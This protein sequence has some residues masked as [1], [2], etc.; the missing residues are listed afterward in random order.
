MWS[1]RKREKERERA[2]GNEMTE[3]FK[4]GRFAKKKSRFYFIT[5]LLERQFFG[6]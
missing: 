1:H 5:I 3:G 2:E 6:E 4:F